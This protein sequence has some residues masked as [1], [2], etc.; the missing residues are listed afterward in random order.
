MLEIETSLLLRLIET[1]QC[2]DSARAKLILERFRQARWIEMG[3]S[4]GQW[5][6]SAG[7]SANLVQRLSALMPTWHSDL[8]LLRNHRLDPY[9]PSAIASLPALRKPKQASGFLHRKTWNAATTSGSK[10]LSRLA[11]D[12]VL[13]DDWVVRGRVNCATVLPTLAGEV[14]LEEVTK[15]LSEFSISERGWLQCSRFAGVLPSLVIT[16]ENIS[17]F[18]DLKLPQQ[19]MLLFS[20]GSATTGA[21]EILRSL[22]SCHWVHFG[23]LDQAGISAG[24]RIAKLTARPNSIF[25]PSFSHEYLGQSRPARQKWRDHALDHPILLELTRQNRWLEQEAFMFDERLHMELSALQSRAK[26]G[27]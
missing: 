14:N 20:Q 9:Q 22:P 13:T 5:I 21:A 23:D 10:V 7:Q 19:T 27:L 16:V 11:T 26:S 15:R 1:G 4:T 24:L 2:R 3:R 25:I 6:V 12:A 18:V 8:V 17:P